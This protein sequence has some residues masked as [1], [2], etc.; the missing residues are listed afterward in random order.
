MDTRREL[1]QNI[2]RIDKNR[3]AT[4]ELI[5]GSKWGDRNSY[6]LTI[7]T[8]DWDLRELTPAAADFAIQWFG[9]KS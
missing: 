3:A 7:N 8:T 5:A 9:R 4:R 1:E 6:H 2:R